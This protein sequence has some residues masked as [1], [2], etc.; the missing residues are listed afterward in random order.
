MG[1]GVSGG[2][3]RRG[4]EVERDWCD[5]NLKDCRDWYLFHKHWIYNYIILKKKRRF[6]LLFYNESFCLF[7][8]GVYYFKHPSDPNEL[9]KLFSNLLYKILKI[10]VSGT[11][12]QI[13]L[14]CSRKR[15]RDYLQ[16][17]LV[18]VF[19]RSLFQPLPLLGLATCSCQFL[20]FTLSTLAKDWPEMEFSPGWFPG[21]G[22]LNSDF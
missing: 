22:W 15:E 21:H 9:G 14:F 12:L 8:N 1:E 20:S 4:V 10:K 16:L 11:L 19:N 3:W 2:E 13:H 5:R 17:W 18:H 7:Q 6:M